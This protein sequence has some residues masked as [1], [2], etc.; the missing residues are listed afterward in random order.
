MSLKPKKKKPKTEDRLF[1]KRRGRSRGGAPPARP[2]S[3]R[4]RRLAGHRGPCDGGAIRSVG[5]FPPERSFSLSHS[6]ESPIKRYGAR[7]PSDGR[8]RPPVAPTSLPL[9][10]S[11]SFSLS[12]FFPSVPPVYRI[13][14]SN[15]AGSLLVRYDTR[16]TSRF[17]MV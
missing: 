8:S 16:C 17:G 3:G 12:L 13:Y 4:R 2:P 10:L 11:L 7:K 5:P 1:R 9:L 6:F 15:H 14:R